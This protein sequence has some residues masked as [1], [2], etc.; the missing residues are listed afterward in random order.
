M[1]LIGPIFRGAQKGGWVC[2][3]NEGEIK[4]PKKGKEKKATAQ[5]QGKVCVT[6]L[7]FRSN[8]FLLPWLYRCYL[9]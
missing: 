7:D 1:Y 3:R 2:L 8:I 9:P 4:R 6:S 5:A